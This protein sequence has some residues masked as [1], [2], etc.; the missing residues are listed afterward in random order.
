MYF[1][2]QDLLSTGGCE[3]NQNTFIMFI[4]LQRNSCICIE[5]GGYYSY[6]TD[7]YSLYLY[8]LTALFLSK[9]VHKLL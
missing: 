3:K 8:T 2:D 7:R 5:V 1:H 4:N 9:P 6:R